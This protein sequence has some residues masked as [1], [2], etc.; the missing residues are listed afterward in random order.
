MELRQ[1]QRMWCDA[2]GLQK[3]SSKPRHRFME[4]LQAV[5]H[6]RLRYCL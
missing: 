1:S 3:R 2:S 4:R 6:E 5:R